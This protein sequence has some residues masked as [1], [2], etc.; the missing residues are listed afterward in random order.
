MEGGRVE[1][2]E[3]NTPAPQ[4]VTEYFVTAKRAWPSHVTWLVTMVIGLSTPGAGSLAYLC[5]SRRWQG[6]GGDEE[7]EG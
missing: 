6:R 7:A 4:V 5:R 1:L 3:K 2:N